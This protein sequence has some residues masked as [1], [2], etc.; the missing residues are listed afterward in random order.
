[1]RFHASAAA[2]WRDNYNATFQQRPPLKCNEEFSLGKELN[3]R[4]KNAAK[5]DGSRPVDCLTVSLRLGLLSSIPVT[6][7]RRWTI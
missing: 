1:M 2:L 5:L 4:R 6:L 7:L 3:G